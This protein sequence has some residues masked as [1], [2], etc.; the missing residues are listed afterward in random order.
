MWLERVAEQEG[1]RGETD[2]ERLARAFASL[3]ESGITARENFT[4]CRN[5]GQ[6]AIRGEAAPDAR[7]FVYFHSQCTQSAAAGDGLTL[8]H[9][10]FDGSPD[11]ATAVE[12]EVV[13]ALDACGLRTEWDGNPHTPVNVTPLNWRRRLV[14]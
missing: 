13:A 4:C 7:G 2:P 12:H 3:E 5:C 1:W 9:G 11:S 8:L 14:G 6:T 10:G